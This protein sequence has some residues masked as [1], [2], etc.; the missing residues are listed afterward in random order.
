MIE[1]GGA[2]LLRMTRGNRE[3]PL[4]VA[5]R[6]GWPTEFLVRLIDAGG[7]TVA[8]QVP[9]SYHTVTGYGRCI[10]YDAA[11]CLVDRCGERGHWDMVDPALL[12]LILVAATLACREEDSVRVVWADQLFR[13]VRELELPLEHGI[14]EPGDCVDYE[15][16]GYYDKD[17]FLLASALM[18]AGSQLSPYRGEVPAGEWDYSQEAQLYSHWPSLTVDEISARAQMALFPAESRRWQNGLRILLLLHFNANRQTQRRCL[19][20]AVLKRIVLE[21]LPLVSTMH[22]ADYA[23]WIAAAPVPSLPWMSLTEVLDDGP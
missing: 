11:Q 7:V 18:P 16:L 5:L 8:R 19:P 23:P 12:R 20:A 14:R 2:E 17:A 4:Q 21:A 13:V 1:L 15:A 6:T 22:W 9:G 3:T 10:L